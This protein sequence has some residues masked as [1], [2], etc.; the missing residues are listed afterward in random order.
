MNA[1]SRFLDPLKRHFSEDRF[2]TVNGDFCC[3]QYD[4][5]QFAKVKSVKQVYDA[6][7]SLLLNIEISVSELLGNI[8]TRD[9]FDSIEN[10]I[11]N[12]RLLTTEFGVPL[13]KQGVLFMQYFDSHKMSQGEP[14]GVIVID[15][16]EKDELYPYTPLERMRKDSSVT[17]VL[18]PHWR[19]ATQGGKELVVTMSMGKFI[20]LRHSECPSATPEAVEQMREN[21]MSW[22]SVMFTRLHDILYQSP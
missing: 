14:C 3:A 15:R 16:V 1:R 18:T 12:F 11:V 7:V 4:V 21:V 5:R 19:E 13:E 9:D 17:I 8:T 2:E 20:K 6:V 22:G 10:S